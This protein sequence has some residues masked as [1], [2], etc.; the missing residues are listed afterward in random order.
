MKIE[1]M[2]RCI[3]D[4]TSVYSCNATYRSE[5]NML[6]QSEVDEHQ[7]QYLLKMASDALYTTNML[8]R[9]QIKMELPDNKTVDE[10]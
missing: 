3:K 2:V 1:V 7:K 8:L 9:N 5:G 6:I 10:R 4:N